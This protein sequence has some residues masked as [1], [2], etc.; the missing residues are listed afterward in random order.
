MQRHASLYQDDIDRSNLHF[1]AMRGSPRPES[2]HHFEMRPTPQQQ[3]VRD[4]ELEQ[5]KQVVRN[6]VTDVSKLMNAKRE[7]SPGQKKMMSQLVRA[8]V[9]RAYGGVKVKNTF[10]NNDRPIINW[11]DPTT[12]ETVQQPVMR[13]DFNKSF[14]DDANSVETNKAREILRHKQE[15]LPLTGAWKDVLEYEK[16]RKEWDKELSAYFS[17]MKRALRVH[18]VREA[19]KKGEDLTEAEQK[20]SKQYEEGVR[21]SSIDSKM[22]TLAHRIAERRTETIYGTPEYL[23]LE[24]KWA[25]PELILWK[26]II[27]IGTVCPDWKVLTVQRYVHVHAIPIHLADLKIHKFIRAFNTIINTPS[28]EGRK[29][30]TSLELS[31]WPGPG[32]LPKATP[33]LP[34]Q[35]ENYHLA[36]QRWMFEHSYLTTHPDIEKQVA[37]VDRATPPGLVARS[38]WC[39]LRRERYR[40]RGHNGRAEMP[41][42]DP[43]LTEDVEAGDRGYHEG[44]DDRFMDDTLYESYRQGA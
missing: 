29:D 1:S 31:E 25:L 6:L 33:H 24:S 12:N 14:E 43:P 10:G 19:K 22:N 16:Y 36:P 21:Q 38:E 17:Q 34:H 13:W 26:E 4:A 9:E 40:G 37:P 27:R 35:P 8:A 42:L 20:V 44:V 39:K 28:P 41:D 11:I 5:V 23:I 7:L 2:F 15:T 30:F 32:P 18:Q 3:S